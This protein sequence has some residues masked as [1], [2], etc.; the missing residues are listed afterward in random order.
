MYSC[1]NFGQPRAEAVVQDVVGVVQVKW[2]AS[3]HGTKLAEIA[4]YKAN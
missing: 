3:V 1:G 4:K 2:T